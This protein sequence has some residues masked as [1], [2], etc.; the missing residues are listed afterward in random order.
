MV[1]SHRTVL[2]RIS[3]ADNSMLAT[4]TVP[5]SRSGNH[6]RL[7][8]F[9]LKMRQASSRELKRDCFIHGIRINTKA[10]RLITRNHCEHH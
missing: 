9:A 8:A 4:A 3:T 10:K 6:I 2:C 1:A 5:S 7:P